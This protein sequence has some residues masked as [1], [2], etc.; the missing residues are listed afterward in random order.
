MALTFLRQQ[1]LRHRCS[2]FRC[3]FGEIDLIM[4]DG[5]R[6]VF[7]E[8]RLRRHSGFGGAA[9]SVTPTKQR[10]LIQTAAIYANTERLGHRPMRF[11]IVAFDGEAAE[12]EWLQDAFQADF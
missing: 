2:N 9:A 10:K 4:E 1:G 5:E 12:P 7:V 8:V 6:V 3:R 11:D